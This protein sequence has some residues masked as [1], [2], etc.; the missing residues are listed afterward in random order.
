MRIVLR[1]ILV[2]LVRVLLLRI[3]RLVMIVFLGGAGRGFVLFVSLMGIV[4]MA[5]AAI[6][7]RLRVS[8]VQTAG[9][10]RIAFPATPAIRA[11][12]PASLPRRAKGIL[13]NS[14]WARFW[15]P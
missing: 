2:S 15:T 13:W 4:L 5:P 14:S 6:C 1:V 10:T 9:P 8:L 7:L 12:E 3:V 11:R